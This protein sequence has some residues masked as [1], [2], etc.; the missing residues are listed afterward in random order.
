MPDG[1]LPGRASA[2]LMEEITR[3]AGALHSR[4]HRDLEGRSQGNAYTSGKGRA[5]GAGFQRGHRDRQARQPPRGGVQAGDALL[6]ADSATLWDSRDAFTGTHVHR[7]PS[8][9]WIIQPP[10]T[11]RDFGLQGGT[12]SPEERPHHQSGFQSTPAGDR[13]LTASLTPMMTTWDSGARP[14]KCCHRGA[15]P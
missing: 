3:Q 7:F 15:S 5:G 8:N 14:A 1:L 12:S 13:W 4:H 9:G 2:R 10:V 11:S 6:Y